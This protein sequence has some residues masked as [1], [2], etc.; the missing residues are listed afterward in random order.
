VAKRKTTGISDLLFNEVNP[1]GAVVGDI[2]TRTI[3]RLPLDAIRPDPDQPRRLL[4]N[5]LADAVN[6]GDM[7]R[8]RPCING[9]NV[10]GR[11]PILPQPAKC[12]N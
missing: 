12:V 7:N 3:E 6:Q 10:P 11:F 4:P 8:S 1:Y 9:F 5:D 2:A